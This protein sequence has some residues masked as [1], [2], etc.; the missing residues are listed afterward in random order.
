MKNIVIIC[1]LV[2]RLYSVDLKTKIVPEIIYLGSLVELQVSVE[3]LQISE[4]P[5]FNLIDEQNEEFTVVNKILSPASISYFIQFWK[6]GSIDIPP[7]T[8]EIKK[9]IMTYLEFKQMK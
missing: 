9:I 8:V 3:N 2:S 1:F 5:I 4:V 7:I 6:V